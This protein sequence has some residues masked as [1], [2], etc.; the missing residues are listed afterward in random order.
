MLGRHAGRQEAGLA[1]DCEHLLEVIGLSRVHHVDQPVAVELP[2]PT[3]DRRQVRCRVAVAAVAFADDHRRTE[4]VDEDTQGSVVDHCRA[5]GLEIMNDR[6]KIIVVGRLAGKIIIGQQH[7]Q[8]RVRRIE[9]RQRNLDQLL[10]DRSG[11]LIP[12]LQR[13]HPAPGSGGELVV[14]AEV[15]ARPGVQRLGLRQRE[16]PGVD[17]LLEDLFDQ[18][19]EL[20]APVADVVLRDHPVAEGQHHPTEAVADDRRPQVADVHLLGDVRR[21]I[22]DHHHLRL[23]G[24]DHPGVR[25]GQLVGHGLGQHLGLEPEVDEAGSGDVRRLAQIGDLQPSHDLGGD[26]P[27]RFALTLGQAQGHI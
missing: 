2:D 19:A 10:P 5:V 15:R 27:R 21:G 13:D 6:S 18:H 1:G 14:G 23:L 11:L 25:I 24:L 26:V 9:S 12:G 20:G 3:P 7:V 22:V 4:A 17:L 16:S 8:P